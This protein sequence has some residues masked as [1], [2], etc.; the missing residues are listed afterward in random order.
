[1]IT[2]RDITQ[3]IA[4]LYWGTML[5]C[6]LGTIFLCYKAQPKFL[7]KYPW[8]LPAPGL[9]V[10]ALFF[11]F[12]KALVW[13]E[14][15]ENA[16]KVAEWRKRYDPAKARFDQLCQNAGEK[17]YR[18]ADNVDGILLLKVRGDDEKYQSNRYNPRKD[19]MWE[20]AAVESES[21]RE[22]YIEEFLLR[23]NL[24]FPRY[25]YA[26]VLQKDNSIIRYSIYKVN[27]EWVEDKQL[28]PHPRAR[29]AVTY[30]N[31]ISWE[32]RKHWIAGTTI[33]I[34][35]TKTNELMAEKTMYAFV[36]ELGY[37]KFEQNPNPW[38]RGMRCPAGESEFEQRTVTFAIKVLIPSN[39]SRRLQND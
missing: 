20:D 31:D 12:P 29:Y 1:M 25:I 34:I 4:M 8:L 5:V 28:N 32:N 7:K 3:L 16:E 35:D 19:Q 24:S 2:L 23:S 18:T 30:E 39:L 21:K 27:Q 37:S 14:E 9:V 26:D 36:P 38:G 33:K 10:A 11:L 22:R 13:Q 17:I 6:A 15:Q